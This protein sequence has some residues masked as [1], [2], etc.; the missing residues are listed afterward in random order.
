MTV[1]H[2]I[3]AGDRHALRANEPVVDTLQRWVRRPLRT[4]L[5]DQ[6]FLQCNGIRRRFVH[7]PSICAIIE[8][9]DPAFDLLEGSVTLLDAWSA[10][11]NE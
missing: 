1:M 9:G 4:Q 11:L 2:A 7:G 5:L 10:E 8:H 6:I 3:V